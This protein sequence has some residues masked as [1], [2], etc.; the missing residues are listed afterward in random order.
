M[1]FQNFS[2]YYCVTIEESFEMFA[3]IEQP[4]L[5]FSQLQIIHL[6]IKKSNEERYLSV[7]VVISIR[8]VNDKKANENDD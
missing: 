8:R 2:H 3:K 7:E 1:K 6:D 5:Q 4:V